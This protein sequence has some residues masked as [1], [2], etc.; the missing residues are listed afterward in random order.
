[1]LSLCANQRRLRLP[2]ASRWILS[3]E[4][5][6]LAWMLRLLRQIG[7][8]RSFHETAVDVLE[9]AHWRERIPGGEDTERDGAGRSDGRPDNY[10]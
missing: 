2:T 10:R 8:A 3:G 7:A 5:F 4:D 9:G 6:Q 1:V